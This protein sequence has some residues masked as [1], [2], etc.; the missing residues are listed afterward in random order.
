METWIF[1]WRNLW[2]NRRRTYITMAAVAANTMVLILLNCLNDGIINGAINNVTSV[3]VGDAQIH[4]PDYLDSR[5]FYDTID[6]PEAFI[7]GAEAKGYK[8]APRR[9]GHGLVAFGSKSAGGTI[10]GIDP[11]AEQA[12]FTLPSKLKKGRFLESA[13][14]KELVIGHRLART[15]NADLGAELVLLIQAADGSMGNEL[16][17]V[18]GVLSEV[19][20]A[21]DRS[22]LIMHQDDF[23]ALFVAQGKVHEIAVRAPGGRRAEVVLKDLEAVRGEAQLKSWKGIVPSFADMVEMNGKANII[24]GLIFALAAGLG[25]MNT[26]LM[27]T[28]DRVRE[29]GVLRALGA[30]PLRILR[31]ITAE[32]LIL[33]VV[34]SALG[35]GLGFG[36]AYI[37][38]T[39]GIDLSGIAGDGIQM[40]GTVMDTML[41]AQIS[42]EAVIIGPILMC[43]ICPLASLYPAVKAARLDPVIAMNH[44]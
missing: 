20:D 24:F 11:G 4:H 2:R 5:S 37:L 25:V 1:A 27:A 16:Y 10:W 43:V 30:S 15:L 31:G 12:A 8:V 19:G 17:R 26:M 34:A 6:N 28:Y 39:V 22:G 7:A 32:A 29:F 40:S 21:V 14:K 3:L 41:R 44:A 13:A 38:Q 18:V 35:A 33:A 36:G 9:F 42:F 23:E